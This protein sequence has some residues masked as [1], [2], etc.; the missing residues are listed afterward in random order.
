LKRFSDYF[1]HSGGGHSDITLGDDHFRYYW[2]KF[3]KKTS[4]L[5]SLVHAGHYKTPTY[6]DVVTNFLSRKITL[7]ARDRCPPERWGHGLQVML[8]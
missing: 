4:S 3:K 7:I 6:A 8:E 2:G 1:R 5:I